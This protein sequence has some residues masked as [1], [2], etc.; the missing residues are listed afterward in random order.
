MEITS[1][2]LSPPPAGETP[3]NWLDVLAWWLIAEKTKQINSL[4][5]HMQSGVQ[6]VHGARWH[7]A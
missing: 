2:Y 4:T 5:F 7:S 1:Q 6:V 3:Y